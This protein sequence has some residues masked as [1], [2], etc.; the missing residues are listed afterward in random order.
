MLQ[1]NTII[2]RVKNNLPGDDAKPSFDFV[3]LFYHSILFGCVA[4]G[5]SDNCSRHACSK[6][7]SAE[8]KERKALAARRGDVYDRHG[9]L[10]AT[11]LKVPGLFADPSLIAEP[12][13]LILQLLAC[14]RIWIITK[15]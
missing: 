8:D 1:R 10:V 15:R 4:F 7:A 13:R 14:F 3:C 6:E 12:E 9:F 11:S 2:L 5:R